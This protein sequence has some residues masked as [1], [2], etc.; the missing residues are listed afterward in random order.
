MHSIR[1]KI[2][3][4]TISAIMITMVIVTA[5]GVIGIR[6]I[7][8]KSANQM[9]SLLCEAG[10]KNLDSYLDDVED[11]VN[12]IS[13]YVEADL[14]GIDDE[15]LALHLGHAS[16]LFK[17]V[18]YHTNGIMTY[19]FRIDPTV[20]EKVK[21]FWFVKGDDGSFYE[22]EVTDIT[23]YDTEDTSKLVWFT[24][25]KAT[26]NAV[27]LHPYITDNLDA[28]V[29]SYNTPVYYKGRFVGVIGIEMEYSFMAELVNNITLYQGGYAF[30][31]DA[32]GNLIYHPKMDVLSMETPPAI[33]QGIVSEEEIAHYTY[34]GVKKIAASRT[35]VNGDRLNVAVPMREVNARWQIWINAI[36]ITFGILMIVLIAF[37]RRY[38]RQI[39]KPLMDLTKVA[40]QIDEG[41]YDSKLEYK[42][43]DEIGILTRTFSRVTSNLKKYIT[44]LNDLA[45]ADA[46]TSLHNKGAFDICVNNIQS[47]M[48]QDK[49]GL[50]FAVCIFDCN[51][52]KNVNDENGHDKGDIYLKESASVICEVFE[53]SPVFR[54]GGDEFATLLL[55]AD[56]DNRDELLK[57]FDKLCRE[58]RK[59]ESEAWEQVD[60]ARGMAVYDPKEDD[61]VND[62]VRRADKNMY[63]NKFARKKNR[64]KKTLG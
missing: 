35:L 5:F 14:D 1:T 6:S 56:Y 7:G 36:I 39:T 28:R 29:I 38:T 27:W 37:L 44:N 19:Y 26:G 2:T 33:P 30:V 57:K 18:V 23:L 64:Q 42:G 31:N 58:K 55:N 47:Q 21:G 41:N 25:P 51:S 52:L 53:H 45:Y 61:S 15:I 43:D 46:L 59:A 49:K 54:I 10:Q 24:V 17:K 32:Q 62:V 63:Q 40:E 12:M 60:V 48:D 3:T 11:E 20:S 9:I 8:V 34:E 13:A 4:V 22:H 16:D 50:Q